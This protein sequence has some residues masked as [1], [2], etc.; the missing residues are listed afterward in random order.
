M[1]DALGKIGGR[2]GRKGP[3]CFPIPGN[4]AILELGV[5]DQLAANDPARGVVVGGLLATMIQRVG[6]KPLVI[7]ASFDKPLKVDGFVDGRSGH[8]GDG[9]KMGSGKEFKPC[10][11]VPDGRFLD[12]GVGVLQQKASRCVGPAQIAFSASVNN[13][14]GTAFGSF[15]TE[16]ARFSHLGEPPP[17][18]GPSGGERKR[19]EKAPG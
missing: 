16:M 9:R 1:L 17:T 12:G 18:V 10:R 14:L 5:V 3:A 7:C 19:R 6:Q 11:R 8:A 2:R 15:V 13:T 4:V